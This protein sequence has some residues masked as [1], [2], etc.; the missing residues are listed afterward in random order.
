MRSAFFSTWA[1]A[2][3]KVCA[4]PWLWDMGENMKTFQSFS[5]FIN[6]HL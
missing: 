2:P 4:R 1:P 6:E 5:L 3:Q